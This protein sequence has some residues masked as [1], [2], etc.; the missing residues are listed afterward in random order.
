MAK[1]KSTETIRPEIKGL[2]LL[3]FSLVAFVSLLSYSYSTKSQNMLGLIGFSLGW[4][5]NKMLGLSSY[6]VIAFIFWIGF[7]LLFR[8]SVNS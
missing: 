4:I 1:K 7:R 8:N 5:L 3:S 6:L 2:Y